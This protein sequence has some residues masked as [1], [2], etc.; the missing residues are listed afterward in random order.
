MEVPALLRRDW[1]VKF[2]LETRAAEDL[3][4]LPKVLAI[5]MLFLTLSRSSLLSSEGL[6]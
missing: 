4:V 6:F 1:G 5:I 3:I 2:P